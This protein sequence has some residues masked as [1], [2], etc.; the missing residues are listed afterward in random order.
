[1]LVRVAKK[2]GFPLQVAKAY[3]WESEALHWNPPETASELAEC[4]GGP[5]RRL[6]CC[7]RRQR[8]RRGPVRGR[9]AGRRSALSSSPA[10]TLVLA[11][12]SVILLLLLAARHLLTLCVHHLPR[13]EAC[14]REG[15]G[16]ERRLEED[17]ATSDGLG[18]RGEQW[19]EILSQK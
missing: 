14:G 9:I 4:R 8:S 11:M 16:V 15:C 7:H 3:K 18:K 17:A 1:M 19:T 6:R 10:W 12:L 13:G 2:K 5:R